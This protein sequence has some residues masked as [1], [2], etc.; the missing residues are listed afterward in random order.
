MGDGVS[1]FDLLRWAVG[2]KGS[3]DAFLYAFDL[4]S[5]VFAFPNT[6]FAPMVRSRFITPAE[7]A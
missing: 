3:R 7:W 5:K 6:R 2:H 4:R 1:D